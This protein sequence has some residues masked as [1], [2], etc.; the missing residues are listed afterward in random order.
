M[1]QWQD[2]EGYTCGNGFRE[3]GAHYLHYAFASSNGFA[4]VAVT[5]AVDACL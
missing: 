1:V 3:V 4:G 5:S 2:L